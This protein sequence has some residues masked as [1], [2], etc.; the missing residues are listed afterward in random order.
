MNQNRIL[1]KYKITLDVEREF[2]TKK[3]FNIWNKLDFKCTSWNQIS[4]KIKKINRITNPYKYQCNKAENRKIINIR[5][6]LFYK[7]F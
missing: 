1:S 7:F 4:L 6:N 2:C 3:I 5:N